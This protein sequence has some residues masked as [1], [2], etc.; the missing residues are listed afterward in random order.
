MWPF[1]TIKCLVLS[2]FLQKCLTW[3]RSMGPRIYKFPSSWEEP[4]SRGGRPSLDAFWAKKQDTRETFLSHQSLNILAF[5]SEKERFLFNA[6]FDYHNCRD[7]FEIVC[8][9]N[10]TF[11]FFWHKL[12]VYIRKL[13]A[14]SFRVSFISFPQLR[15]SFESLSRLKTKLSL[16][17]W[18]WSGHQLAQRATGAR[19]ILG[20]DW[21]RAR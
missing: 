19:G 20:C 17:P 18:C 5:I 7:L 12:T 16:C 13:T 15:V 14:L 21:S 2:Y 3:R 11:L 4:L 10:F 6:S 1:I 8:S 9:K